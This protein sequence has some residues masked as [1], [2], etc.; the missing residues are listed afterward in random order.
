MRRAASARYASALGAPPARA[1]E[2][3]GDKD[4]APARLTSAAGDGDKD[5]ATARLTL[6]AGDGEG[7]WL[8]RAPRARSAINSS[9]SLSDAAK[10]SG[11]RAMP[12]TSGP[13]AGEEEEAPSATGDSAASA[14]L[15]RICPIC[16]NAPPPPPSALG[17]RLAPSPAPPPA[18]L[19]RWLAPSPP[20]P[21]SVPGLWLA[22]SP[23]PPQSVLDLWLAPSP[24]PPQ[25]V[26]GIRRAPSPAPPPS[27]LGVRLALMFARCYPCSDAMPAMENPFR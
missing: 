25:S 13:R 15:R 26:P 12:A 9:E 5:D 17:L 24:A 16:A 4:A 14:R 11:M 22:P 2:G 1:G 10:P 18:V 6:A 8:G 3:D 20:P 27:V 23:A 19:G 7:D 21:P